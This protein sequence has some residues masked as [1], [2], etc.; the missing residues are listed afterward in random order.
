VAIVLLE[1]EVE[2]DGHRVK[3]PGVIF[4]SAGESHDMKNVGSSRA[5][6]VVFEFHGK[7]A[8]AVVSSLA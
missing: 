5:I 8:E 3:A 6:Y 4:Y 1:G 2:T 7:P